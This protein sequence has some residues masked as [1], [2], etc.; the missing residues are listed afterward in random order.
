[1]PNNKITT[2]TILEWFRQ[3][4]EE[5]QPLNPEIWLNAAG[6]LAI[7]LG[8]EEE[9]LYNLQQDVAEKKLKIYKEMD[10]PTVNKAEMEIETTDDYKEYMK[11]KAKI[12]QIE[13]FIRLAKLRVKVSGGI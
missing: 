12:T 8:D 6:K 10:K 13:E 1:M 2:D 7:L 3:A 5:K 11:Q 4:V 9:K